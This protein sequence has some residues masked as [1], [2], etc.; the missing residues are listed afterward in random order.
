MS[1]LPIISAD[2]RL[3]ANRGIKGCILG[4][5]GIGKTSLLWTLPVESTLFFDLE[6]GDLAVIGWQ[7]DYNAPQKQT[8]KNKSSVFIK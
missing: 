5:Y 3:A 7:G 2:A 1:G 4:A 8:T 6:A